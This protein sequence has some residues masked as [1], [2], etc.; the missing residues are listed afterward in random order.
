MD[1]R[2]LDM[3]NNT[4]LLVETARTI[5]DNMR[6]VVLGKDMELKLSLMTLLSGGHLLI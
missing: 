5:L 2:L 4:S 6:T 1:S 3:E